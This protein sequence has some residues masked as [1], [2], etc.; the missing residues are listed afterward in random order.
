MGRYDGPHFD[1]DVED[2]CVVSVWA[3]IVPWHE[4]PEDYWQYNLN[5]DDDAPF[6]RFSSDFGFGYY[7]DDFVPGPVSF[8]ITTSLDD[9]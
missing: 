6:N 5:G 8:S 2:E 3:S 4:I 7:D 9:E 1:V